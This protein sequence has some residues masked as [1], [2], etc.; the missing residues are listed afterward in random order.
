MVH[1]IPLC[2]PL[3]NQFEGEVVLNCRVHQLCLLHNMHLVLVVVV[4]PLQ[5]AMDPHPVVLE[6]LQQNHRMV[7]R[8]SAAVDQQREAV[9]EPR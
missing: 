1:R 6:Q 7:G 9:E 5:L 4:A 8:H 2:Y 3:L